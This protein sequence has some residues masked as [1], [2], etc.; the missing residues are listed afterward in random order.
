MGKSHKVRRCRKIRKD[1]D[2]YLDGELLPEK[3][4]AFENHLR[5]CVQCRRLLDQM[6]EQ[7]RMRVRCL[8]P[9]SSPPSTDQILQAMGQ[10]EFQ[11]PRAEI[12]PFPLRQSW[13]HRAK[14]WTFRPVPTVAFAL[15]LIALGL[16]LFL[17]FRAHRAWT[18]GIVIE[19]VESTQSVV[20]Y[21]PEPMGPTVM[22][23]MPAEKTPA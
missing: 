14:R 10:P 12:L 13:W 19:K 3:I 2:R 16:S 18:P 22:W 17:P 9:Q 20:I 7:R 1:M 8:M 11:S 21:Q 5:T 6:R 4:R 15:C 23:I